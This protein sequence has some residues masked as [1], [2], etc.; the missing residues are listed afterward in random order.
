MRWDTLKKEDCSLSR[1]LAVIGDRWT[2][3]ILR[4]AFLRV[5]RFEEF[6]ASLKIARRV[7]SERLALLVDEGILKK[8]PY[9]E[10][11]V[12]Y[13]YRL[14][15]KGLDLYP[16]I[17]HLVHW[18][19]RHYA[20]KAGPPVLHNHLKCGHDFRATLT[21]SECGETIGARDVAARRR[22]RRA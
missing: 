22:M 8:V 11:P 14:T 10:R 9:Q 17:L 5:R 6:E 2:L 15:E 16:A 21:C 1:T 7:L 18:G 12:R 4:D 19:D 20:T 3:L 13:E